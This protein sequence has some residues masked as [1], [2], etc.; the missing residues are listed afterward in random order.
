M[1]RK[2]IFQVAP[3]LALIACETAETGRIAAEGPHF[4]PKERLGKLLFFDPNLSSPAGQACA[5]CH[6]P[7][8]GF[9][10]PNPAL[11][12]S[13]GVHPDRFGARNDQT[14]SYAAFV[15]PRHFDETE[16]LWVGGLFWDGRAATL[17]DQAKGPPLNPLE[18][19]NPDVEAI[20]AALRAAPYRALFREVFGADALDDAEAAFDHMAEAIAAYERTSEVNPFSSKYDLYLTGQVE[21][22]E[23]ELRG[24]ALFEDEGKGN[25]AACHPS[26]PGE[27]GSPP[28]FTDFTYDNLGTPKNPE[29]PFYF[30]SPELN[31]D[32]IDYVDLGLGAV[33]DDPEQRGKFRV[34]TLRNVALTPPYMHNGVFK[35]LHQVVAFYNSRDVTAWPAPEVP[36]NV[37]R[38][39][40]GDLGL[41]TSEMEDIVAFM[42]ALSDGYQSHRSP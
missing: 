10:D 16:G 8:A 5:D 40:L 13:R 22:T 36:E 31:P 26:R 20:A 38:D 29:N 18:M 9:G 28:L 41:T 27:D 11:P 12:V 19:A 15:P 34:P 3:V 17:E 2:L 1:L 42:M 25:C 4:T 14:A 35:T 39:E 23:Q 32:G 24:L 33:V 7:D 30:L 6:S 21:L 37:N